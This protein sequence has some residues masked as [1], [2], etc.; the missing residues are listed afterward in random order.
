MLLELIYR[1]RQM[2]YIN[3]HAKECMELN[4]KKNKVMVFSDG[5]E[6]IEITVN[7]EKIENVK[8]FKYLGVVLDSE[9]TD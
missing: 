1:K 7:L 3:G 9:L 4:I 2:D 8:T 5:Q 6:H